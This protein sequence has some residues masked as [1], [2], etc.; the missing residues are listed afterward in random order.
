M[1]Q[2]RP[3]RSPRRPIHHTAAA[4]LVLVVA[5]STVSASFLT[6]PLDA[7]RAR[8]FLSPRALAVPNTKTPVTYSNASASLP[9]VVDTTAAQG[10]YGHSAVYLPPPTNELL[11]IGGQV[12]EADTAITSDVLRFRLASS[13]VWAADRPLSSIPDNP[14][15]NS[16]LA[17]GLPASAWGAAAVDSQ[18]RAWLVGGVTADCDKDAIAHV[19]SPSSSSSSSSSWTVPALAPRYPPRRRQASAL[20]VA[21]ATTGGTDLWVLGGIA[22]SWTCS[23]D[24]IG[25]AGVDRYDTVSGLVESMPWNAPGGVDPAE[26]EPPVSDYA[27][28]VLAGGVGILIVGGQGSDGHLA[29]TAEVLNFDVASRSWTQQSVANLAPAPRMGHAS[30]L[31]DSGSIVIHGG[32]SS[33]HNVLSDLFLLSPS[34]SG[35]TWTQLVTS[36]HSEASPALA[37]HSATQIAG[38]TIVVA[39][40]ID[41]ATSAPSGEFWF[42]TVDED[43]GTYTWTDQFGGNADAVAALGAADAAATTTFAAKFSKKTFEVIANPKAQ[44]G[45]AAAAAT[46]APSLGAYGTPE[47]EAPISAPGYTSSLSLRTSPRTSSS[48]AA[49]AAKSPSSSAATASQDEA[50]TPESTIIG[51]SLGAV[52]AVAAAGLLLFLVRRRAAAQGGTRAPS[53]PVM[54]SA[55][56]ADGAAPPLVSQLMY[57]RRAQAR[58]MSLGSTLSALSPRALDVD[59]GSPNMAGIGAASPDPFNDA[60]RVTEVGQL[61]RAGSAASGTSSTGG[62]VGAVLASV[63]GLVAPSQQQQ[64]GDT[65]T[66]PAPTLSAKRSMR[67]PAASSS[68]S[69]PVPGTPAELIGMAITSDDGHDGLPYVASSTSTH[70]HGAAPAVV[71]AA[72]GS[73]S[74]DPARSQRPF[75]APPAPPVPSSR[76]ARTLDLDAS[77]VP[78]ILRPG[79]PLRVANPDPFADQ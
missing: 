23:S 10:R 68:S 64:H 56:R 48:A 72:A 62:V 6:A 59:E 74:W 4:A 19:L 58:N 26:W 28:V 7:L 40:G 36:D 55:S 63:S 43:A 61:E 8:A 77:P 14:L 60:Y 76:D 1:P 16:S 20:A 9:T 66:S 12:G 18:G 42:L 31:L 32:L 67:R 37:Y 3:K 29:D 75:S 78:A 41:G 65:Y 52:G 27:A 46:V 2:R 71:A 33:A 35:W 51:A 57:T 38:G 13:L 53:S 44:S 39:F 17:T 11:L 70:S 24:T 30:V 15:K 79:T 34:T 54:G 21:N 25:Y 69:L 22:D 47:S 49:T 45:E 5:S 50:P 73:S